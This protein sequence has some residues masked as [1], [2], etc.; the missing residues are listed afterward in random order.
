MEC[1]KTIGELHK[2]NIIHFDIKA[3]NFFVWPTSLCWLELSS[4][5]NKSGFYEELLGRTD[6][7][8]PFSVALGDFGESFAFSD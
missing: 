2:R 3:D 8:L 6:T 4:Q 5:P 1:L 7:E